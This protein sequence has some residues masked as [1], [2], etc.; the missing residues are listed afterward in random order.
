MASSGSEVTVSLTADNTWKSS[1]IA[2]VTKAAV[3]KESSN[4]IYHP[5]QYLPV[6]DVVTR[7]NA[8]GSVW[9]SMKMIPTG[10]TI[11]ETIV[12]DESTG[13]IKFHVL[14]S[15]G[16]KTKMVMVNHIQQ[17]EAGITLD[18]YQLDTETNQ[19]TP[20]KGTSAIL[21]IAENAKAACHHC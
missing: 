13:L 8:D 4:K 18:Y 19:K 12:A 5:D 1:P 17:E 14:D 10:E 11:V 15:A 7:T 2:G 3:W 20:L 21:K 9:R 16:N 6:T